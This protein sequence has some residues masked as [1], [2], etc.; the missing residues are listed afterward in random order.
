MLL[1]IVALVFIFGTTSLVVS[2]VQ[3]QVHH[4]FNELFNCP[5]RPTLPDLIRH[6]EGTTSARSIEATAVFTSD[7]KVII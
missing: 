1:S 2:P 4:N 3:Q 5:A 6:Q 7:S